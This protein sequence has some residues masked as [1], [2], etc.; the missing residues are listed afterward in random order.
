MEARAR[1]VGCRAPSA[2]SLYMR[3]YIIKVSS[4]IEEATTSR[5]VATEKYGHHPSPSESAA[6]IAR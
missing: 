2:W 5:I 1:G 4:F 3:L 6:S